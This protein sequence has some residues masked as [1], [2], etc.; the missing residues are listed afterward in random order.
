ME[1]GSVM[2]EVCWMADVFVTETNED[3]VGGFDIGIWVG[4]G[5]LGDDMAPVMALTLRWVGFGF[6]KEFELIGG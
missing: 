3:A 4:G 6:G 1:E 5:M 2:C